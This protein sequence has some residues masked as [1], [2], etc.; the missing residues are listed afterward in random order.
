SIHLLY[1]L[2]K[3]F[4]SFSLMLI[5]SDKVL[6]Y[7]FFAL[8][9]LAIRLNNCKGSTYITTKLPSHVPSSFITN[10]NFLLTFLHLSLKKFPKNHFNS[11][12]ETVN[13]GF[14][15]SFVV[16]ITMIWLFFVPN[17]PLT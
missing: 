10:V 2:I 1:R 9:D 11:C 3:Y 15:E 12:R 7:T 5:D 14:L 17:T 6:M 16:C 4:P 8:F 13:T